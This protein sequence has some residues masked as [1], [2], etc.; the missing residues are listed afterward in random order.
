LLYIIGRAASFNIHEEFL[1][2]ILFSSISHSFV[3][4]R[5]MILDLWHK[6]SWHSIRVGGLSKCIEQEKKIFGKM[7][8][9]LVKTNLR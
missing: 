5:L 9:I 2:A 6:H 8:Q 1:S 7:V 4:V 3:S